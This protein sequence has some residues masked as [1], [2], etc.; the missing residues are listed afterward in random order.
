MPVPVPG[1]EEVGHGHGHGHGGDGE[2][3]GLWAI[4]VVNKPEVRA[5]DHEP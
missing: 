5:E 4:V 1:L 3:A 2:G